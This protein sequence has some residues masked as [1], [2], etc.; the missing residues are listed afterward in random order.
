MGKTGGKTLD[1]A[2]ISGQADDSTGD[3]TSDPFN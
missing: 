1:D 3:F 2:A